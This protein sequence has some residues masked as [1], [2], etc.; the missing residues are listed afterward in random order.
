L[1]IGRRRIL[2]VRTVGLSLMTRALTFG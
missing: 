2:L 1:V